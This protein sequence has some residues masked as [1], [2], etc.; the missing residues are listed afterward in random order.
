[1][2]DFLTKPFSLSDIEQHIGRSAAP[3]RSAFDRASENEAD[4][5]VRIP[6]QKVASETRSDI[7]NFSAIETIRD[8][9]RQTGK[10]ILPSIFEGYVTQMEEKLAELQQNLKSGDSTSIY[11]T[12]HAIK[13]MSANIGAKKITL[14][15]AAMEKDGREEKLK[16]MPEGMESLHEAYEEFVN[17]FKLELVS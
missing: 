2:T 5:T 4:S 9:E 17:E 1:M 16:N 7:L 6:A 15:S 13:S 10:P 8:V 12:A 3:H 14:I 11:R